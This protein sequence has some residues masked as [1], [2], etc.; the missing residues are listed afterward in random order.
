MGGVRL[1]EVSVSGGLTVHK[2][3]MAAEVFCHTKLVGF[4][5]VMTCH[6]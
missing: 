3:C 1:Q 5:S 2:P 4:L 6:M